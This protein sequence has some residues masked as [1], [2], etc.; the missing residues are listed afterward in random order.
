MTPG[1]E[2][3]S[4]HE[5]VRMELPLDAFLRACAAAGVGRVA[6]LR[7]NVE[8]YGVD[9]AASLLGELGLAVS[10]YSSLGYWT[11][12][13]THE[14]VPWSHADNLRVLDDAVRLG[15]PLAVLGPGPL[16]DRDLNG[17]RRRIAAGIAELW[18]HAAERG[19]R[20]AVEPLHPMFCPERSVVTSL[21]LALDLVEPA[22]TDVAGVAVDSYHVWW[23]PQLD[24]Q[25]RRARERLFAVHVDDFILPLPAGG[26]RRG[27]MGEGCIDLAGFRAAVETLGY[28]GP[29]EVEVLN[30][31]L[32]ALPPESAVARIADSYRSFAGV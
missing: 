24:A 5:F 17:A 18:P 3:L 9:R 31:E 13:C 11:T 28:R 7:A 12:G 27:L 15:A 19:L 10:S 8:A 30:E 6:L 23:D 1:L 20:L 16:G 4:V 21:K 14:G 26:R 22:P 25:L 29:Y 2:R 32:S